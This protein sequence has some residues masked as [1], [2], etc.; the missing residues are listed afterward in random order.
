MKNRTTHED[1]HP[2]IGYPS[3]G[4]DEYATAVR[5][6]VG[7]H[8][9]S[10]EPPRVSLPR[11]HSES[12]RQ[13]RKTM[14]N[15][16]ASYMMASSNPSLMIEISIRCHALKPRGPYWH[17]ASCRHE[18][19]TWLICALPPAG[20]RLSNRT[21]A[22]LRHGRA[23]ELEVRRARPCTMPCRGIHVGWWKCGGVVDS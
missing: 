10:M 21:M 11:Q 8:G 9:T 23:S 6:L 7:S 19:L 12:S 2:P 13:M 15:S 18:R 3:L 1:H 4:T 20:T 16:S 5:A 22:R 14:F 17:M